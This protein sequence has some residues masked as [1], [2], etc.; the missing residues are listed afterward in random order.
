MAISM[1]SIYGELWTQ[2][3]TNWSERM[4]AGIV[5]YGCETIKISINNLICQNIHPHETRNDFAQYFGQKRVQLRKKDNRWAYDP[6]WNNNKS[7]NDQ[8]K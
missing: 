7:I 1:H 3:S 2:A 4:E 8:L 6:R 5:L